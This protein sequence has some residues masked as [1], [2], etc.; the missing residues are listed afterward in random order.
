VKPLSTTDNYYLGLAYFYT[1]QNIQSDSCFAQ[2]LTLTPNYAVD[3]CI[4]PAMQFKMDPESKQALAFPFYKS[5][6]TYANEDIVK[7]GLTEGYKKG[8][9][10]AYRYVAIYHVQTDS[11]ALA[12]EE[13]MKAIE[14]DTTDNLSI[15]YLDLVKEQ[16]KGG[17]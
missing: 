1:N 2:I 7:K 12:K 4:V 15:Q 3:G 8:L 6:I 13:F 14:M 5:Y 9:N 17:K 16:I 10:E 11:L